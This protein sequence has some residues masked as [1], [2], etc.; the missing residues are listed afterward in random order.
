VAELL[1]AL[2][3]RPHTLAGLR[4]ATGASRASAVAALYALAAHHAIARDPDTDSWDS[5]EPE[6]TRYRLTPAGRALIDE[7]FHLDVWQAAYGW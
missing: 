4:R 1:A 6:R 3:E 2:D 7:L 5:I